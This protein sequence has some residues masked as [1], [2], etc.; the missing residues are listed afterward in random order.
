MSFNIV[1]NDAAVHD[2]QLAIDYYNQQQ[3]GLGKRFYNTINRAFETLKRNPFYQVRYDNVRCFYS[4]PFPFLIHFT[5][6]E[7]KMIIVVLAV[8]HTSVNPNKWP[9]ITN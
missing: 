3:T 5:V 8:I 7:H 2:I 4:R 9:K 6:D 1:L